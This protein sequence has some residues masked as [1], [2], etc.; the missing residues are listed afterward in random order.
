MV[1]IVAERLGV[2]RRG[3]DVHAVA[4]REQE[5]Q[6]QADGERDRG[7][8]LEIDQRL[9]ADAADFLQIAGAGNAVHHDAEH[10]RRHDHLNK[11]EE[12]V[13]ED[14]QGD[15]KIRLRHAQH[16]AEDECGDHLD[17]Q[18]VVQRSAACQRRRGNGGGGHWRLSLGGTACFLSKDHA[19]GRGGTPK[20]EGWGEGPSIAS[21]TMSWAPCQST[22]SPSGRNSSWPSTTV[23]K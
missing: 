9:E 20:G 21:N 23:R 1:R 5:R 14:L 19:I 16:D 13:A 3:V 18:R 8:D 12:G 17:E 4:G 11:L 15:R 2:E 10:D 22:C 6:H 7:H